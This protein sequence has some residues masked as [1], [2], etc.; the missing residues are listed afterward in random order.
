[1]P[2]TFNFGLYGN[3][4]V[5]QVGM[6]GNATVYSSNSLTNHEGTLA[7]HPGQPVLAQPK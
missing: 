6:D 4:A 2:L 7:G 1:V 3:G 5:G